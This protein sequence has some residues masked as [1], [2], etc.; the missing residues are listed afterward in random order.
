M[1]IFNF[2]DFQSVGQKVIG[3]GDGAQKERRLKCIK[4][5]STYS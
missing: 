2:K 5:I 3:F 1:E 4:G